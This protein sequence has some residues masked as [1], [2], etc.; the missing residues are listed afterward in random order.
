MTALAFVAQDAAFKS[1][2]PRL[3]GDTKIFARVKPKTK[4]W[5]V[6]QLTAQ[7]YVA[8][9]YFDTID[10]SQC[11]KHVGMTGAND[12][13]VLKA[14]LRG[15][16]LSDAEASIGAI[17]YLEPYFKPINLVAPFT[18]R[19]K[20]IRDVVT[21]IQEDRCASLLAFKYMVM[22]PVIETHHSHQPRPSH[23]L[24]QKVILIFLFSC[25]FI[26]VCLVPL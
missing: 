15:L 25:M 20:D 5:I 22:Y 6:L 24:Q 2:L 16:A 13:G 17:W 12:C 8:F 14:A 3:I 10:V 4:T 21:L 7:G 23:V 26:L 1:V 19:N 18:S 9:L 11:R